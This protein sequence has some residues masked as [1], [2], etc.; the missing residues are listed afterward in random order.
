[1]QQKVI[2]SILPP[3]ILRKLADKPELRDRVLRN[4]AISEQWRGIRQTAAPALLAQLPGSKHRTIFDAKSTTNLPGTQV[5]DEGG[6]ASAD[7]AVNEAYQYTGDTYDFYKQVFNRNSVDDHGLTLTSSVHYSDQYDNALWNGEQMIYGDGDGQY[8]QRFTICLD[9]IGHELT[10]GVTQNEAQLVYSGQSGALNESI[11]DVFGSLVKQWVNNQTVDQADWLIGAGLF[12]SAVQGKAIRSMSAP[13]TAYNDPN[14]GTDPQPATIDRYVNTTDDYGGVH[15]N[16]GIPNHAFYLAAKA[17]GGYAWQKAGLIW[18][19]TLN[20]SLSPSATFQD[21]SNATTIVAGSLFGQNSNE[22][23][24]VTQ[25][26]ATVGVP[27]TA[28]QFRALSAPAKGNP[29]GQGEGKAA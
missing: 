4:L 7:P 12:T 10:H 16:S 26:W 13:G 20:G 1:M 8:F 19:R 15:I 25:A 6:P 5:L 11:S 21:M 18:Y 14:I 9:V 24:A 23:Q 27:P 22:Q 29:T 28:S 17:I 2:C 3:H